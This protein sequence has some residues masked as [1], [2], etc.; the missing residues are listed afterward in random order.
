[1][2][3]EVFNLFD[4][5]FSVCVQDARKVFHQVEVGTHGISQARQL[6]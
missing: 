2:S 4:L 1:M 3:H 5:G 6:T